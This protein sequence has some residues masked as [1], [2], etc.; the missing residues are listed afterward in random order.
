MASSRGSRL[1]SDGH[2]AHQRTTRSQTKM[3]NDKLPNTSSVT[4]NKQM[5][6]ASKRPASECSA[7]Q[8]EDISSIL[9]AKSDSNEDIVM[10][11]TDT[12]GA[13]AMSG[14][15]S[16][17]AKDNVVKTGPHTA[18]GTSVTEQHCK[19]KLTQEADAGA[20]TEDNKIYHIAE[21]L[22]KF[23]TPGRPRR[24]QSPSI[25]FASIRKTPRNLRNSLLL[26]RM[27]PEDG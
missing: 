2:D 24:T 4:K 18:E 13:D 7:S 3:M 22:E 20:D 9:S 14:P 1:P 27:S 25:T 19:A 11:H 6:A 8:R 26:G 23:Q 15:T 5:K 17:C 10:P 16:S 12:A 21:G